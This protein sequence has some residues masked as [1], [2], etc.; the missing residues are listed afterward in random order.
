[1]F[2]L[3]R[4]FSLASLVAFIIVV[5]LLGTVYRQSAVNDLVALEGRSNV[6]LAQAFANSLW[7]RFSAHVTSASQYTLDELRAHPETAALQ[8]AVMAQMSGLS[9]IKVKVY[10][11]DGLVVFST[12]E[13]QIG[14]DKSDNEGLISALDGMVISEL[15]HR[16]TFSAFEGTIEDRDVI[17][18][19]IPIQTGG[20]TEPIEAIFELYSDVTPLMARI[21]SAQKRVVLE[22]TIVLASLYVGLFIL[23]RYADRIIA[24]QY[25]ER[26][27]S[28]EELKK[29]RQHLEALVKERTATLKTT[30]ERL[31]QEIIDHKRAEEEMLRRTEEVAALNQIGRKLSRLGQTSEIVEL[32]YTNIGRVL[33]NNNF[34]IALYEPATEEL[35]FPIYTIDGRR[36]KPQRYPFGNGVTEWVIGTR[37]PLLIPDNVLENITE[38]GIEAIDRPSQSLLAVPMLVGER[39][40]G[41]I[42]LQDYDQANVY[43]ETHLDLLTTFAAQATIALENARLFSEVQQQAN[44]LATLHEVDMAISTRL[45]PAALYETIVE[46]ASDLLKCDIANLFLWDSAAQ[47]YVGLASYG[48]NG[49]SVSGERFA[50]HSSAIMPELL[51]RPQPIAIHDVAHDNRVLPAWRQ[52]FGARALLV[53]PLIYRESVSGFLTLLDT[54][55]PRHWNQA[56]IGLA[57]SLAAQTSIALENARLHGETTSLLRKTRE[58]TQQVRRIM[59]TVSDGVM[60]LNADHLVVLANPVAQEYLTVLT[61]DGLDAPLTHLDGQPIEK[62]LAP[63]AKGMRH[64]E[65]VVHEPDHSVFEVMAQSM[66][67]GPQAGSWV[68]V[69]RDV[70]EQR[71]RQEYLQAQERLATVGQLAAGIAHDFN[72]IM[73][74]I[75]LYSQMLLRE[76]QLGEKA[77][78]RLTT[79][80]EQ[81]IRASE[82]IGQILDF[83]RRSVMERRPAD[84]LAF[85]KELLRLLER[86]LPESIAIELQH[87]E[88]DYIVHADLTRLQQVIMNLALNARD[89]MLDGGALRLGV[90]R[91]TIE[92]GQTRPLPDISSGNWIKLTVSDTGT[93]IPSH[94]LRHIYEPFFTTKEQGQGTGLGLAQVYG[95][96]KQHDGFINVSSQVGQGTTF[97]I[98]L[99]AAKL[100][101]PVSLDASESVFVKGEHETILLVEDDATTGAAVY[102]ALEM[103]DYAVMLAT[104]GH[105][106]LSIFDRHTN[107]IALVIS[108]LVMPEMGGEALLKELRK[109]DPSVKAIMISGYPLLAE[110]KAL[111]EEGVVAWLQKPFSVEKVVTTVSEALGD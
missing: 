3:L 46:R 1:M 110:G 61:D 29:H 65:L 105:E 20:P 47:E 39:A 22:V 27:R 74:V 16:D 94:L 44:H 53:V 54:K 84:L 25:R 6:A 96:V 95:I 18:S 70:T 12:E 2:R 87:D 50:K 85:L 17:S 52:R 30:N 106:A 98:Y 83:S 5:V 62:L 92:P 60:L 93:G 9:V 41:V 68:L 48:A 91:L 51:E 81:A 101:E 57:E 77:Q 11:L 86:T 26:Q 78:G 33:D 8:K 38:L 108:D 71:E 37:A 55:E 35:F 7:P 24:R 104:N 64:H 80:Y 90:S 97:T 42:T 73:A 88:S 99:P 69:L 21:E 31:A 23:V 32:I 82:L 103:A 43:N 107:E 75:V 40:I 76:S 89:A 34:Y 28:E 63:P 4:Y 36:N 102:D 14:D 109:R 45:E 13:G 49:E 15:T 56:E 100:S 59:D 79:I 111:V 10:N 66:E 67:V 58:Q 72:N 19:Y